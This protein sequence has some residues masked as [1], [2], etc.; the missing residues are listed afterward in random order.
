MYSPNII[1]DEEEE[2]L[3]NSYCKN[4]L[5]LLVEKLCVLN[6]DKNDLLERKILKKIISRNNLL[7]IL[8]ISMILISF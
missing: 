8:I 3:E 5:D 7:V 2:I 1:E 6:T 4:N